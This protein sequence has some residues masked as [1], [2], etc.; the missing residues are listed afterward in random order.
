MWLEKSYVSLDEPNNIFE[1]YH[2]KVAWNKFELE[3]CIIQGLETKMFAVE[4]TEEKHE[5]SHLSTEGKAY[6]NGA[7]IH[8]SPVLLIYNPWKH[9]KTFRFS[10]FRGIDKQSRAL[11]G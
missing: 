10:V 4:G 1:A 6:S 11:V 7:L 8:Y 2:S 5:H 3:F 9:Q